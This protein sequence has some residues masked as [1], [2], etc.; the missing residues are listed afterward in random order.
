[1]TTAEHKL[2][3]Y[4]IEGQRFNALP[5]EP[6]LYLVPTPIGNLSD[7]TLRALRVLASADV[8]FCE[9][10]RVTRKLMNHFSIKTPLKIYNDHAHE[11][12]RSAII[13]HISKGRAIALASD[14]G[15]P[16]ISDPGVKLVRA[17]VTAGLPVFALPGP[18]ATLT[19]LASS[20]LASERFLF[21]GFI[22][23]KAAQRQKFLAELAS[24]QTTLILF[25]T[26][27]RIKAT[28]E[29]MQLLYANRE[30][31]IA[32]ELTKRY[33]EII[34]GDVSEVLENI[35]GRDHLKGEI[36]VII[37]PAPPQHVTLEDISGPLQDLL[38]T[39]SVKDA[40]ETLAKSS[41]LPR[42]EIYALALAKIK[43]DKLKT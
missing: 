16:L 18:S 27:R 9:D 30:I 39:H 20:G 21:A 4:C 26:A 24:Q 42:R 28:L 35:S 36:V 3:S 1:V 14:A 17:V 5:V 41:G 33:E 19:A 15:M 25:E 10:T 11:K 7:I 37:A 34:R 31:A 23:A 29:A 2:S 8:I 38:K 40:S 22:P 13:D 6:G 32:R 43:A 12:Q